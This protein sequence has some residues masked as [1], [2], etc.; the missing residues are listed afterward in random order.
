MLKSLP[1]GVEP[2]QSVGE[3]AARARAPATRSA[4]RRS[5]RVE[6]VSA[7]SAGIVRLPGVY[8]PQADTELL[9]SSMIARGVVAGRSVLD[10]CT[11]TGAVAVAAARAGASSVTAVDLSR[12]AVIN[13]RLNAMAQAARVEV[14]RGDLF[15]PVA[16][17]RFDVVTCNPPYVPAPTERLPRHQMGR[18][19]DA[20]RDGRVLI[21]RVCAEVV[22]VLAPGGTL[23]LTHSAV[24]D[25][26]QTVA[27]LAA[28]GFEADVV[29]TAMV[30]FGPVMTERA[31]YLAE[32]GLIE[33][34]QRTEQLVVVE[35]VLTSSRITDVDGSAD[36]DLLAG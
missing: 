32:C 9:I 29:A 13:A 11:G 10:V 22:D 27:A 8:P 5:M 23:L 19:W 28:S 7:A 30:P 2:I 34:A 4:T 33:P 21:D 16:G 1:Q 17:R 24:S 25:A 20:G 3:V 26:E 31:D 35:A 12:R 15:E 18:C 6:H 14:L 36:A